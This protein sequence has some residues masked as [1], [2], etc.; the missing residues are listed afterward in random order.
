MG[1]LKRKF[2]LQ[3]QTSGPILQSGTEVISH[4][5]PSNSDLD[6]LLGIC[7]MLGTGCQIAEI[8]KVVEFFRYD[9]NN[10]LEAEVGPTSL[11]VDLNRWSLGVD[12]GNSF[13]HI[14]FL[15]DL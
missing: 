1:K 3:P 5:I 15:L 6:I 7:A 11:E 9:R 14:S 13:S 12:V 4:S 10:G 2:N 8:W